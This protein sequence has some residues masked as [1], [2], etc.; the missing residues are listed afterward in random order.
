M[1]KTQAKKPPNEPAKKQAMQIDLAG[2]TTDMAVIGFTGA[3]GSGCSYI[4]SGLA[5]HHG[6]AYCSLS[7][8]IHEYAKANGIKET[9]GNLQ[10][11]GNDFRRRLGRGYLVG[12][13]MTHL[14][15][16]MTASRAPK[17]VGIVVDGIRNTGEVDALQQLPNFFL[18]SV[19]AEADVRKHRLIGKGKKFRD[20]AEFNAADDRDRDEHTEHGQQVKL[21]NYLS[22]IIVI[23]ETPVSEDASIPHKQYIRDVIYESYVTLI[24]HVSK[25][26]LPNER[27]AKP[28]EALMTAAYVESKRS[29]CLKRKV[30][31]VIASP[32]GDIIAAGHNDV[33]EASDPC[34][35]D[36]R[37]GWCA[38]DVV[39]ER[40]GRQIKH[41]PSCGEAVKITGKCGKCGHTFNEYANHCPECHSSVDMVYVCPKCSRS[42]FTDF[43]AG[44]SAETGKLLDLCRSLHAEE[45][46]ILNLSKFGVRLPHFHHVNHENTKNFLETCV[47]FSTTFPC[48]LCANKIVTVGIK[49]VVYAEPY[50]MEEARNVFEK[51]HVILERFQGV[52]SRAFFRL[53]A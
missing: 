30:G 22:D 21:C 20:E 49:K 4:A 17:P 47:L 36:A 39:Q 40:L 25:A 42:V 27:R 52:K 9:T 8:P 1:T 51:Q 34:L 50:T 2:I 41:C 33:P 37:Y 45:N 14:S 11:I 29:S 44:S 43:L 5:K 26:M 53:Y 10:D 15:Q 12:M 24:E 13:A 6:Y 23:N 31:A 18:V 7:A 46:A 28:Q 35:T 38:R 32:T 48:N 19:Q 3:L 16:A